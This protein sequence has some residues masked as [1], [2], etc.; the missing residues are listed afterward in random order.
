MMRRS[1]FLPLLF[2]IV[3]TSVLTEGHAAPRKR[4]STDSVLG[5]TTTQKKIRVQGETSGLSGILGGEYG[6]LKA[7]PTD[8]ETF[9]PKQG[10]TLELKL[11]TGWL[12][13]DFMIDSGLGFYYYKIR[14]VEKPLENGV[15]IDGDRE[16]SVSGLM[17]EFSPSYR[18]TDSIF[19]GGIAQIRTPGFADY[20]SGADPSSVLFSLGAQLGYQFF[21]RELNSRITLKTITTLGLKGW[22]DIAY[23]GGIQFGLP[24]RQPDSLVIRKTTVV[25]KLRDVVEYRKKDFT[26]TVSASV[27]KL[28]LDNILTFYVD[29]SGRPTL[30]AEAQSFLIDLGASL[31]TNADLFETL[32]IDAQSPG[33]ITS[34]H[35]SLISIGVSA[36]KVKKGRSLQEVADGGNASVDFTFRGVKDTNL[37]AERI[38]S[39][40]KTAKVPENC[41]KNGTCE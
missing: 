15:R 40:M 1:Y 22:K 38:R 20:Y 6:L 17:L 28:A 39:A 14:G 41:N 7:T 8:T 24:F 4:K 33:H 37:L 3:C 31:T 16:I 23:L 30:T 25:N 5:A 34:V 29:P 21:D 36:S 32:R 26:I 18:L 9:G 27:V 19:G 11:L 13:D 35:D 10:S 12:F 2:G